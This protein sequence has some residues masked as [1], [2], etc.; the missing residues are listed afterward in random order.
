MYEYL[1]KPKHQFAK[2][3]IDSWK[4]QYTT[5]IDYL[6]DTQNI[7]KEMNVYSH[8]VTGELNCEKYISLWKE[9][10][11][12]DFFLEKYGYMDWEMFKYL[13]ESNGFLQ[14][15]SFLNIASPIMSFLIPI[16]FLIFPFILLKIQGIPITF[17]AYYDILI[18]LAKNHFIGKA[19]SS[20]KSI[21]WD[22]LV[23]LLITFSLYGLQIYQNINICHRFYHNVKK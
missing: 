19:L 8:G 4:T 1:F 15:I 6:N 21:S 16:F 17:D 3:M 7:L 2:E 5:D 13:N 18:T 12:D 10:K 11:C 23:Y 20:I 14:I 22:K 9:L